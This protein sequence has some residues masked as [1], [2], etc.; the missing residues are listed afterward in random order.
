[1]YDVLSQ[2]HKQTDIRAQRI[3]ESLIIC[4]VEYL[5]VREYLAASVCEETAVASGLL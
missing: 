2:T 1:M 5:V 3:V 4:L